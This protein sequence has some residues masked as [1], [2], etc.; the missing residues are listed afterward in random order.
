MVTGTCYVVARPLKWPCQFIAGGPIACGIGLICVAVAMIWVARPAD[1][2]S[3]SMFLEG[4][5]HRTA[6]GVGGHDHLRPGSAAIIG[7][8]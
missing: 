2:V 4:V 8:L 6:S 5:D 7:N 3:L 1:G